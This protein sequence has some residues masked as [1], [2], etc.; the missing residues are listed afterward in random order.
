[1]NKHHYYP[2]HLNLVSKI[3]YFCDHEECQVPVFGGPTFFLEKQVLFSEVQNQTMKWI[4]FLLV[5]IAL[6]LVFAAVQQIVFKKPFGSHPMPDWVFIPLFVVVG[7]FLF[8]VSTSKLKTE[9]TRDA[10]SYQF[11]P[12]INQPKVINW[13]LYGNDPQIVY[14]WPSTV[15]TKMGI[16]D[17]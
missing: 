3:L 2:R 14:G 10:I 17:G 8:L 7:F 9:I 11:S 6:L 13:N 5:I 1:M 16:L 12:C 15:I 4:W